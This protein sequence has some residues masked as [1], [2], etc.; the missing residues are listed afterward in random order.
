SPDDLEYGLSLARAQTLGLAGKEIQST[1]DA[2]RRL[3]PPAGDDPRIDYAEAWASEAVGDFPRLARVAQHAAERAEAIEAHILVARA[4]IKQGWALE[5]LGQPQAALASFHE[6]ERRARDAG[7]RELVAYA[8]QRV[9][10]VLT[11]QGQH[12]EAQQ[13]YEQS[14]ATRREIG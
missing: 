3:P 8:M 11:H 13:I 1:V 6:A 7:D 2:L 5:H 10:G 9:A 12:A 14:I 4:R